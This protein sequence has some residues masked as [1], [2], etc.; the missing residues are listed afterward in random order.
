MRIVNNAVVLKNH[1]QMRLS[2]REPSLG[3]TLGTLG[4][5]GG[6]SEN[7]YKIQIG[8]FVSGRHGRSKMSFPRN[9]MS[10]VGCDEST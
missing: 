10:C 3:Q 8:I 5:Y 1:L 7:L 9:I 2:A 6:T 4:T